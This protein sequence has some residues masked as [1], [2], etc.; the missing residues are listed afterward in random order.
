MIHKAKELV[1]QKGIL[2]TRD[3]KPR[4]I[5]AT[6]TADFYESNEVSQVM[7]GKKILFLLD[8]VSNVFMFRNDLS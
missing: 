8:N 6:E 5:L 7:P 2:A 3:Q 1:K 4:H